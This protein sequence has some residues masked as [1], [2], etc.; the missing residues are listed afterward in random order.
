MSARLAGGAPCL[1]CADPPARG[2]ET[3]PAQ[4]RS[5]GQPLRAPGR[6]THP[7]P[8]TLWARASD[9]DRERPGRDRTSCVELGA[10]GGLSI[11]RERPLPGAFPV[12]LCR[13]WHSRGTGVRA[14]GPRD[15]PGK[16]DD[17]PSRPLAPGAAAASA[18]SALRSGPGPTPPPPPPR[19]A[20]AQPG[21][22]T[23]LEGPAPGPRPGSATNFPGA[24]SG[25]PAL[26]R[27]QFPHLK[28]GGKG[29]A[30]GRGAPLPFR[31]RGLRSGW[32]GGRNF[33]GRDP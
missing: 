30:A 15:R 29:E 22:S 6:G 17:C 27:P 3:L 12:F 9:G 8:L 11:T 32:G 10:P 5:A 13:D 1:A 14:Q 21:R 28:A 26:S 31:T 18:G 2:L 7:P 20:R 19:R 33:R 23:K 16:T 25:L 24:R 4:P